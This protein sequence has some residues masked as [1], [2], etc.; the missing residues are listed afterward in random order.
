[1]R[2]WYRLALPLAFTFLLLFPCQGFAQTET[3]FVDG[4]ASGADT[5]DSWTDAYTFLQDAFDEANA[6]PGT[7]FEIWISAGTYVPDQDADGD[8][9]A[10]SRPESFTLTRDGVSVYGGF[11]GSE[12][13]RSERDPVANRVTLSG[14]IGNAA[15]TLD[16]SYHVLYLDGSQVENITNLTVL[17]GF[18]VRDGQATGDTNPDDVGGGFYCDGSGSGNVCS[19]TLR[20]LR[21]IENTAIDFGGA[22]A[23]NGVGGVAS[24]SILNTVF[25]ENSASRVGGAIYNNGQNGG[26]ASPS[27]INSAFV[28]NTS[29]NGGAIYSDGPNGESSPTILNSVF[30]RNGAGDRGGAI[31]NN[32]TSGVSAPLIQNTVLWGNNANNF[33]NEIFNLNASPTVESSIVQNGEAGI[34]DNGGTTTYAASN[35]DEDPLFVDSSLPTGGDNTYGT[36]DDGL[37]LLQVSPA[38]DAGQNGPFETGGVAEGISS[39]LRGEARIADDDNDGT[40]TVDLGAYEGG[41]ASADIALSASSGV[42][43]LLDTEASTV[44]ITAE[45]VGV[46]AASGVTVT[47]TIPSSLTLNTSSGDG[48]Y[49]GGTWDVG[50]IA[51]G[52]SAQLVLDLSLSGSDGPPQVSAELSAIDAPGDPRDVNNVA[53]A[54]AMPFPYGSGLSLLLDGNGDRAEVTDAPALDVTGDFTVSFWMKVDTDGFNEDSEA[55]IVKG[56]NTWGVERN[57]L[58]SSLSFV[59][60]HGSQ[61]R[62]ELNGSI[63][64]DD[65][66]WHHVAAVYDQSAGEKRIYIDGVLDQST[67][68]TRNVLTSSDD[69]YVG[70]NPDRT[71]RDFGGEMDQVQLWDDALSTEQVRV[72]ARR[73]V[74]LSG[75]DASNLILSYRFDRDNGG[76]MHDVAKGDGALQNGVLQG[77]A[78]ITAFSGAPLGQASD[79]VGAGESRT[80]GPAGGSVAVSGVSFSGA[81]ALQ[82]HQYGRV[83]G[84][85]LDSSEPTEDFSTIPDNVTRRLNVVW[86]IDAVGSGASADVVIDYSNVEGLNNPENLR[87]LRRVGPGAPWSDVSDDWVWD[88]QNQT[89]SISGLSQFSQYAIGEAATPIPVELGSFTGSA[90]GDAAAILEWT[91]LSESNNSGF[92]VQQKVDGSFETVSSLIEGAGTTTEQQSYRFRAENLERGTTHTFRLRQ[93]DVDGGE[94]FSDEINIQIGIGEA[95]TLEAYPNPIT[96]RQTPTVRFAVEKSQPVTVEVYNTLGQR[97]RTLY[98][99]TPRTTGQFISLDLDAS[100]LS[101]GVYFIRM[102]GESFTTTEKLVVVR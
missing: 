86:G 49:S 57:A 94:S 66:A 83:D 41:V 81:S 8:H 63:A 97:V 91:T 47:V 51:S 15:S 10:G 100:S 34:F 12:T 78:Q 79:V 101:S 1:M 40:A 38:T 76:P 43:E 18:T 58:G 4:D 42:P 99:D 50:S 67:A 36:A 75:A 98:N 62:T 44:T 28:R 39:D 37:R 61:A 9:T 80:L 102:Q 56:G 14:N 2:Y 87:L 95:Y 54:V 52:S 72:Q 59:T 25:E 13:S 93:V 90:D 11:S 71:G 88:G 96:S 31:Y 27:I 65:G 45:N 20:N 32:G 5:G 70:G 77:D 24:P 7:D 46:E 82:L 17:D 60:Y 35:I 73:T 6:S 23:N 19:P 22:I 89:F 74:D 68:E 29:P 26:T 48:T 84:P 3:I 33:G 30:T 69:L 55:L 64:V 16:N 85:V 53:R 92:F 21:F